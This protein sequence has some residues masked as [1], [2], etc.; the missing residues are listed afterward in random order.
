MPFTTTGPAPSIDPPFA[1]IPFTVAYSF[2]VSKSQRTSPS[3]LENARTC[4]SIEPEKTTPGITVT[5]PGWAGL[6]PGRGGSHGWPGTDQTC[7]PFS[8]RNAAKPPPAEGSK[9]ALPIDPGD[10]AATLGKSETAA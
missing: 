6:Q 4:P 9:L 3:S 1:W 5:A 8:T 10:T 2:A 7:L